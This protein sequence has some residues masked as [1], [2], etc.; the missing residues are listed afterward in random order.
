MADVRSMLRAERA[1]RGPPKQPTVQPT[2][3]RK[4]KA[5]EQENDSDE[6]RKRTRAEEPQS[7]I[8][9]ETLEPTPQSAELGSIR[10]NAEA[11]ID[12]DE[13]AAFEREVATPPPSSPPIQTA[14]AAL[15]SGAAISA[16]P[17]TA[18]ELEERRKEDLRQQRV[19][20]EE[21]EDAEAEDA[22]RRL[23]EEFEQMEH[24]EAQVQK[25]KE[26]RE[27]LRQQ[28]TQNAD[29]ADEN[30]HQETSPGDADHSNSASDD[31]S[32]DD[33]EDDWGFGR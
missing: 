29:G 25:L 1:A 20:K 15:K 16:A 19:Q 27:R 30:A 13:W 8:A 14:L 10:E 2:N 12:E 28:I 4:R 11:P 23:E 6:F 5:D 21:D 22:S 17:M 24:L 7:T 32:E 3:G 31:D 9:V 26:M 33:L 18:T